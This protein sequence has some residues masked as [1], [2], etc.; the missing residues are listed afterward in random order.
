MKSY[1]D[2]LE[3]FI[4]LCIMISMSFIGFSFIF[5]IIFI[6]F[7]LSYLIELFKF[8]KQNLNKVKI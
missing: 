5:M 3:I 1:K 8:T 7:I 4:A 6:G 2:Y